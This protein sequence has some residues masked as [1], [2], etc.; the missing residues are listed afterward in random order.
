MKDSKIGWTDHTHNEWVGCFKVSP[1]CTHCYAEDFMTKKPRWKNT[2]GP[3]ATTTRQLTTQANRKKP[4][5]WNKDAQ[6]SGNR[7][8]VFTQSLSDVFEDNWRLDMYR[9]GLFH[10]IISTPYLKW[11][12][13]TKRPENAR[14]MSPSHWLEKWPS[15]VRIGA[16]VENQEWADKRI[17]ELL[18]VPAKNF[19]S[20]EPMLNNIDLNIY[21]QLDGP[22]SKLDWLIIG[23]ESGPKARPFDLYWAECLIFQCQ[24]RGIPV[25]MKQLGSKPTLNG[26]PYPISDRKGE[27]MDDWPDY[28]KIRE[29]PND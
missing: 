14:H 8:R 20:V 6:K 22:N 15:H 25:F 27:N 19:L 16:S 9:V 23:G 26:K 10:T 11:L 18:K 17:P 2:W 12:V 24:E 13:L 7:P 29:F 1:G 4:H 5:K 3:A 28:L 21:H